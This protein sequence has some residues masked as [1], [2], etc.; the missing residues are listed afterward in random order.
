M[1]K[2]IFQTV[3][4]PEGL[5]INEIAV[6]LENM[7]IANKEKFLA[8]AVDPNLLAGLGLQDKGFEG[9][10]FPSTYHFA[11]DTGTGHHSR[12]PSSFVRSQPLL[13]QRGG[14]VN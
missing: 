10:L 12:W 5:T 14:T 6:L 4:I 7:Q 1:G 8:A 3:T 2:G 9:Y 13:A 11:L